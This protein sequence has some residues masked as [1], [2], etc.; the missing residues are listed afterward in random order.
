[1]SAPFEEG[2]TPFVDDQ[3]DRPDIEPNL[4]EAWF[5][6]H[7]LERRCRAGEELLQELYNM[8]K[9]ECPSLL[10]EDRGGSGRIELD[11]LQHL[12]AAK[13]MDR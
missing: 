11:V 6:L 1:M 5:E 13:E 7:R 10:D 3:L 4:C 12:E 2:P 8:V 9:G